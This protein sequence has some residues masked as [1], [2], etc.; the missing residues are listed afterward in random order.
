MIKDLIKINLI[1]LLVIPLA[2]L[3]HFFP[4]SNIGA[5]SLPVLLIFVPAYGISGF[6]GI[7]NYAWIVG[8]IVS[9]LIISSLYFVLRNKLK[10]SNIYFYLSIII[11]FI[12]VFIFNLSQIPDSL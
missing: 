6:F 7:A 5:L 3:S 1:Y 8:L 9:M 2:N 12:L 10:A 11:Y 4:T